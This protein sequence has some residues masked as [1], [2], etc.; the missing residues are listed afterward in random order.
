M[1]YFFFRL[2]CC[3]SLIQFG[4]AG[5]GSGVNAQEQSQ[6]RLGVDDE[7]SITVFQEPEL[8]VKKTRVSTTGTISMPLIGQVGVQSLTVE[9]VEAKVTSLL[10]G[11]Y[12]KKPNV[13]VSITEYR[14]FYINGEVDKPGSY[15]YRQD[16]TIEKAVVLAGGFTERASRTTIKLIREGQQRE[17]EGVALTYQ[18]QPGDVITVSESFF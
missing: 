12:L 5:F 6:Y 13:T 10:L 17:I 11:D 18:V 4:Y 15:P 14:P 1:K 3:L 16:L 8:S 9:E 7:I 2:L